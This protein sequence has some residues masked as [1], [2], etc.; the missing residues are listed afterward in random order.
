MMNNQQPPQRTLPTIALIGCGA[1]AE[2]FYLPALRQFAS[3]VEK[4]ILVDSN[5]ERARQLAASFGDADSVSNYQ[6]IMDCI[7]G[8]IVAVPHH[9]H[10]PISKDLLTHD[11]HV[12]CEKPLAET[13]QEVRE[14]VRLADAHGVTI[15]VNNTRRL[16]PSSR[17]IKEII[18]SGEIGSLRS[19]SYLE[20]GEFDWPTASGF[21]FNSKI[22]RKGVLLDLGAHVFDVICFWL[23]G[24][25]EILSSESDSFGGCEAVAAVSMR[26]QDC[27]CTVR[28]SRLGK[29][30]NS[31]RIIGE[32]GSI[33]G[34]IHDWR[35][36]TLTTSRGTSMID[37][38]PRDNGKVH[39]S[40]M[41][42]AN[43]LDVIRGAAT[44]L[45][46]ASHVLDSI[47]LI[48]EAY[49]RTTRFPLPWYEQKE[50]VDA[51]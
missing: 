43:F 35:T 29:L 19:I 34:A 39:F 40:R 36:I 26:Y 47:E 20:G 38:Q 24:K 9:L 7:Q 11:V 2:K 5:P 51:D 4:V 15:A 45:I 6:D 49:G 33:E 32:K 8:A 13:G 50:V 25:P 44:P 17:K 41:P 46:P 37:T 42:I 27:I 14:M 16:V 30:P 28:M 22:S 18:T 3:G 10:V 23:G 1:I 21:Y 48:Q 31:F 12:L